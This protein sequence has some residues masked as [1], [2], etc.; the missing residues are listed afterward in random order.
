VNGTASGKSQTG[1]AM[2]NLF[3]DFPLPYDS[4]IHPFLGMGVGGA[5][6]V[7]DAYDASNT[8]LRRSNGISPTA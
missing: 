3:W 2:L 4:P 8:Y 5:Y 1:A 7:A 6:N